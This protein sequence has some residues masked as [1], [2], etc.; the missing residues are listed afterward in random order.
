MS[1]LLYVFFFAFTTVLSCTIKR[2]VIADQTRASHIEVEPMEQILIT[3]EEMRR[4]GEN[5]FSGDLDLGSGSF[6]PTLLESCS[7]QIDNLPALQ[8][9]NKLAEQI[10]GDDFDYQYGTIAYLYGRLHQYAMLRLTFAP[11]VRVRLMEE[12]NDYYTARLRPKTSQTW[13]YLQHW[14]LESFSNYQFKGKFEAE[15]ERVRPVLIA[16]YQSRSKLNLHD[17]E[18]AADAVIMD[19]LDYAAGH[20]PSSLELRTKPR[21][22]SLYKNKGTTITQFKSAIESLP[23]SAQIDELNKALLTGQEIRFIETLV[24]AI[25]DV[26]Q[27]YESPLFYALANLDYV[28]LLLNAGAN[29]NYQ[30]GFGKTILYYAIEL[31][32]PDLINFL[33]HA[34]AHVNHAYASVEELKKRALDFEK[35]GYHAYSIRHGRRTPLMHAAQH[36]NPEIIKIFIDRGANLLATDDLDFTARDYAKAYGRPENVAFLDGMYNTGAFPSF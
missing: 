11:M 27:G 35:Y 14:Y 8:E 5:I 30:N 23:V 25:G 21:F 26:N 12:S 1:R 29:V 28:N 33:I 7:E 19:I 24:Q 17:A 20:F 15:A 6:S 34:G 4:N 32:R 13:Q 36:S 22:L 2:S 18:K 31:D 3:C 9:L 16:H 10:R